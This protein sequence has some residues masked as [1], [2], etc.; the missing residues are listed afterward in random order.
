MVL[1]G[2]SNLQCQDISS[3]CVS[4]GSLIHAQTPFINQLCQFNPLKKLETL[5]IIG[6]FKEAILVAGISQVL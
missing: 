2:N 3:S 5:P 1:W 4:N 6:V